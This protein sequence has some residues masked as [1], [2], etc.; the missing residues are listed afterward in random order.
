MRCGLQPGL[1]DRLEAEPYDPAKAAK[2]L[3][4]YVGAN[5][6]LCDIIGADEAFGLYSRLDKRQGQL[7]CVY[8]CNSDVSDNGLRHLL[9][10]RR[11]HFVDL[12]DCD[13]VTDATISTLIALPSL[14]KVNLAGTQI[15][16]AAALHLQKAK[17]NCSIIHY[18]QLVLIPPGD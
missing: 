12:G 7:C 11:V 8:L 9:V 17:P 6:F 5:L 1:A 10:C 18:P 16:T 14:G 13:Q 2:N 3:R 4:A 15:T